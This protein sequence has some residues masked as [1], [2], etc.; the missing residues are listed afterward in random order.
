MKDEEDDRKGDFLLIGQASDAETGGIA[1]VDEEGP[2]DL[3]GGGG[4]RLLDTSTAV[5]GDG[6]TARSPRLPCDDRAARLRSTPTA[7]FCSAV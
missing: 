3:P 1:D 4:R 7:R 5:E 6:H 2:E